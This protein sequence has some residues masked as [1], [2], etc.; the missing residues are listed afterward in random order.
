MSLIAVNKLNKSYGSLKAVS[1]FSFTVD[2]G[3]ILALVGPD[4]AGKTT[5]FR[6]LCNLIEYESG[7]INIAGYGHDQFDRIKPLLGYMPQ[8]FSLYPDL[9]VDENLVFYAGLFGLSKE[10][11]NCKKKRLY[12]FS[13]LGP[14]AKRRASA[15]SGGM[16]Q[17]LALSC[18][19]VHDPEVLLL[20]EPTT[21]V[22]P[23]SRRQFWDIL[24]NLRETGSAIVVSTPY[25]DEVALSNRAIFIYQGKKLT[26][27][28]P[29]RLVDQF[30]GNVYRAR[31]F[32]SADCMEQL[33]HIEGLTA[34][35]FGSS[36][37]I[38]LSGAG[39]IERFHSVLLPL[40][41]KPEDIEPVRPDLEDT[42]IQLIG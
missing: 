32:P 4:G 20:D 31:V 6:S 37:H 8:I 30:Q 39:S 10:Q 2:R 12:E 26:E 21:G 16:K 7:E 14:F 3:E 40:G 42:F 28:T 5:I 19:L 34:R 23:L 27:G 29:Q 15:L 24:R 18:C 13:G 9:S 17:K 33:S 35:R 11:F 25:M 22:D 38:Y 1:D 36:I 41:I